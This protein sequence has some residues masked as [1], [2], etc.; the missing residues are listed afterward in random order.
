MF[1]AIVG[2]VAALAGSLQ[3]ISAKS[4]VASVGTAAI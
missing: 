4:V 1:S 2:F 3:T